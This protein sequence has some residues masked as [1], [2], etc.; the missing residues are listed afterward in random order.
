MIISPD[1][2]PTRSGEIPTTIVLGNAPLLEEEHALLQ[3]SSALN[4]SKIFTANMAFNSA[5]VKLPWG[6]RVAVVQDYL[7]QELTHLENPSQLS[8]IHT[9][10]SRVVLVE[11]LFPGVRY[12]DFDYSKIDFLTHLRRV[13]L[14]NSCVG[15]RF[16]RLSEEYLPSTGIIALAMAIHAVGT[17]SSGGSVGCVGIGLDPL[18][19]YSHEIPSPKRFRI[20]E[21]T[22]V[23]NLGREI[24]STPRNHSRP[25]ALAIAAFS[26]NCKIV[27]LRPEI[28]ALTTTWLNKTWG[29][30]RDV[31]D[32]R[33]RSKWSF[34]TR[35]RE[36][37]GN[38]VVRAR[39]VGW[40]S[41][42]GLLLR[43]VRLYGEY[44]KS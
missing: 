2:D 33:P 16:F 7:Y 40:R 41:L 12:A 36:I 23:D 20:V 11:S 10:F 31:K 38:C 43:Q 14:L 29:T 35:T 32:R 6:Q 44:K 27:S 25:D 5:A 4:N 28:V 26:Y 21:G 1:A 30:T 3:A 18:V 42:F 13:R 17:R 15:A 19:S 39:R 37:Y 22:A 24:F 9:S 34:V 8:H